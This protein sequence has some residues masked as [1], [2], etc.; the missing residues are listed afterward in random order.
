MGGDNT[1]HWQVGDRFKEEAWAIELIHR[2][3]ALQNL[4]EDDE[5]SEFSDE[6]D[7]EEY[8]DESDEEESDEEDES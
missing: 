1:T 8:D 7:D 6:E 4:I 2:V 5:G 3:G